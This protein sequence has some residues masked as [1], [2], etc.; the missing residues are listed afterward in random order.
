MQFDAGTTGNPAHWETN[1]DAIE[2][3]YQ[4]AG[5]EMPQIVYWNLMD[6]PNATTPVTSERKGVALMSGF[7]P[8]MLK[9]FMGEIDPED[10]DRVGGS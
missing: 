10:E 2:K 5:Y 4:A 9:V 6:R 3:A 7:S 1:H 8:A